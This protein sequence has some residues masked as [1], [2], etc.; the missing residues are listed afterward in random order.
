[1]MWILLLPVMVD[2]EHRERLAEIGY[3]MH[4]WH[5]EISMGMGLMTLFLV[6]EITQQ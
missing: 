1:M 6:P 2:F 3:L 4:Q 5:Q